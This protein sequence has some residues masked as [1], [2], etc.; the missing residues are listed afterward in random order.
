MGQENPWSDWQRV[1]FEH[2]TLEFD[3][4]IF[5]S[6][7]DSINL[8]HTTLS[9][10]TKNNNFRDAY[11]PKKVRG[12]TVQSERFVTVK[13]WK[14]Y[15]NFIFSKY[16]DFDSNF[17]AMADPYTDNPYQIADSIQADWRKQYYLLEAKVVSPQ[18]NEYTKAGIG[19][20]YEVLNGARQ[21]DPRPLD[22]TMNLELTPSLIFDLNDKM[23]L[24]INGYYNHLRQ[25]LTISLENNLRSQKIYKMLGLGEYLYNA[26]ILLTGSLSRAYSGN[27]FGGG[28]SFGYKLR[29]GHHLKSILGYKHHSE[30]AIDGT[31]TPFKA[32]QHEYSDLEARIVF[33][34]THPSVGHNITFHVLN[35]TTSDTEYIQVFNSSTQLYDVLYASEMHDK[36]INKLQLGYEVLRKDENQNVKWLYRLG[37]MLHNFEETY[38]STESKQ[39]MTNLL[40]DWGVS[41]WFTLKKGSL[42]VGYRGNFKTN[43]D[44]KFVYHD[45]NIS[46]NFIAHQIALPNHAFNTSSYLGT[47]MN[48]QYTFSAFRN[49][50]AHLYLKAAYE[51]MTT[52]KNGDY[53]KK[54]ISNN[55]LLFTVGLY[56]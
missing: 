51:N 32:G 31:S 55:N 41:R 25:D 28:L 38:P 10:A 49:Y 1:K 16:E 11:M 20:K 44:G 52:L 37:T 40:T 24:G 6:D 23:V 27:T 42:S 3:N 56:N 36:T 7:L 2:N 17:S 18:I 33:S 46:T 13:D 22:N 29:P 21:R 9:Y 30:N 53:Y 8:G 43:L 34:I 12:F 14:V 15:G 39:D 19:V 5:L 50:G 54:G 4:P 47:Q 35:R 45:K 48:L 26:P